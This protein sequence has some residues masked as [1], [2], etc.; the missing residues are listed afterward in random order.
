[1]SLTSKLHKKP[2]KSRLQNFPAGYVED[3][4]GIWLIMLIIFQALSFMVG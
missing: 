1:M 4:T 3:S 2:E